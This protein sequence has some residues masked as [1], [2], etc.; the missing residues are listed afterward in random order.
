[1]NASAQKRPPSIQR[2]VDRSQTAL[3]GARAA[4]YQIAIT[5]SIQH[6]AMDRSDSGRRKAPL[7]FAPPPEKGTCQIGNPPVQHRFASLLSSLRWSG[8]SILKTCLDEIG[9]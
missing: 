3:F 2:C 6:F 7:Y 9:S 1:M 5:G 4:S 8:N